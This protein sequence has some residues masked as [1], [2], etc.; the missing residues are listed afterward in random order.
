M[1]T[2]DDSTGHPKPNAPLAS[3]DDNAHLAERRAALAKLGTLAAWTAPTL[4]TLVISQRTSA[5]SLPGPPGGLQ[6]P[7]GRRIKKFEKT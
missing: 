4:F 7:Q 6:T 1:N 3:A 5:E 2:T